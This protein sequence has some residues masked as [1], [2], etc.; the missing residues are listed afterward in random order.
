LFI[1]YG[2]VILSEPRPE[3]AQFVAAEFFDF[4]LNVLYSVHVTHLF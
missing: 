4:M 3:S 2:S 1:P